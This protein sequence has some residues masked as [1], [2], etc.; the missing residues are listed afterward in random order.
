MAMA[1]LESL[2]LDPR[3]AD[4]AASKPSQGTRPE[5]AAPAK[6]KRASLCHTY[7]F[8]FWLA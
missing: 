6:V 4:A 2:K 7:S 1:M 5:A 3:Q 8:S